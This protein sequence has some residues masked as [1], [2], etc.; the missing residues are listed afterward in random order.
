MGA[1]AGAGQRQHQHQQQP[2]QQQQ[3]QALPASRQ[4]K[5]R[6]H[7][8]GRWGDIRVDP[9]VWGFGPLTGVLQFSVSGATQRLVQEHCARHYAAGWVPGVGMCPRLW[10]NANGAEAPGQGLQE[11]EAAQKRSYD[12]M[13][14]GGSGRG[15]GGGQ[16]SDAALCRAY[17][18]SWMDPSPPRELPRQRA[19]SAAAVVT[20]Q[21]LEQQQQR[22]TE[23]AV[24]DLADPLTGQVQL[25]PTGAFEWVAVFTR[26]GHKLLPRPQRVFGWRMLHAGIAVPVRRLYTAPRGAG[27]TG[28]RGGAGLAAAQPP[29]ATQPP[30]AAQAAQE[31]PQQRVSQDSSVE[32]AAAAAAAAGGG[33]TPQ[34]GTQ[35]STAAVNA[36]AVA[37]AAAGGR[38]TQQT[39]PQGGTAATTTRQ[40]RA[41]ARKA[42]AIAQFGCPH[43]HCQRQQE[44]PLD[45]L[46]HAFVSCP[47]TA[48]VLLWFAGLWQ[49]AQP[50]AAA[51]VGDARVMLLDDSRVW[52]PPPAKQWTWSYLRLL[53]L[54]CL[55]EQRVASQSG[56]R[57]TARMVARRFRAAAQRQMQQDWARV[58]EDVRLDAG[59]PLSW[60]RGR[61]PELD[62][63]TF[64]ARWAGLVSHA[65]HPPTLVVSVP[66]PQ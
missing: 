20:A 65:Q 23:L 30:A 25:V 49:Q 58:G 45:T 34:A 28:G 27:G 39:G 6:L 29:A 59:V 51:P 36:A 2:Q 12:A 7:L 52:A 9:S 3:R 66:D 31:Q 57:F 16:F 56:Q 22:V 13:L 42:A 32:A 10:R 48:S 38:E 53:L 17:H 15:S 37:A 60:L 33:G 40:A 8:V 63:A 14:Q 26:A 19:A 11:L 24:N 64:A 21:R 55:W 4:G 47:V 41:A 50:G 62:A 5:P 43:S 1:E 35:G 44:P 54:E 46:T 61:K 18:A